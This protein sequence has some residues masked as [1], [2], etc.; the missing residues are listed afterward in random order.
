MTKLSLK[1]ILQENQ[2]QSEPRMKDSLPGG[3]A[4]N[5]D[6]SQFDQHELM[7]GIHVEF[8]HTNDI[9]QAMEISMDHLSEDP[10][11]YKKLATIHDEG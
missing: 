7:K 1:H 10:M 8:E 4:D 3:K 6:P 2:Q 9:L 5:M 11:Y